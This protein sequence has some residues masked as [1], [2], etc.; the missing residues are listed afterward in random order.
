M[1]AEETSRL[2]LAAEESFVALELDVTK[3]KRGD[4]KEKDNEKEGPEKVHEEPEIEKVREEMSGEE[5]VGVPVE[6]AKKTKKKKK[7]E[8]GGNSF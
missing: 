6:S 4:R 2:D 1:S 3:R 7:K 5:V 8:K